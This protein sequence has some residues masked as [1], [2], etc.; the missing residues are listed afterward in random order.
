[1]TENSEAEE[2]MRQLQDVPPPVRRVSKANPLDSFRPFYHCAQCKNNIMVLP[3]ILE[4]E[5]SE[6]NPVDKQAFLYACLCCQLD[7][8]KEPGESLPWWVQAPTDPKSI[9]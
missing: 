8:I 9:R 3:V 7:D 4:D 1:M 2:L 5:D 6:E